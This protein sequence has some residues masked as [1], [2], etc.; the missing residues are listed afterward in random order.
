MTDLD[1]L[2]AELR[3][4]Q[5]M[6]RIA[7]IALHKGREKVKRLAAAIRTYDRRRAIKARRRLQ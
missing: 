4:H 5:Q 6:N 3:Y 7:Q 2:W 1:W